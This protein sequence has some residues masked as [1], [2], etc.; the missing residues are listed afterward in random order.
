V[1]EL[2][3]PL[4]RGA[5]VQLIQDMG[6]VVP[7]IITFQ[8]N[9]EKVTRGFKPWNPFDVDATKRTAT[10]TD[11]APF[12][13]EETYQFTL[14]LDATDDIEIV[15]P[16]A[17][18]TGVASRIAAIQKLVMPSSGLIGDLVGAAKALGNK[19]NPAMAEV[20]KLPICLLVMGTGLILPVRV[21][22]ISVEVNEY[23]SFLY[24]LM[25]KVTLDL[26]VLTP[27]AFKCKETVA[28]S[29]AKSAYEFTRLQEDALAILNIANVFVDARSM[30]PF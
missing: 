27:E 18:G 11:A 12:D 1:V 30:L 25:A 2:R 6:F 14:E 22:T 20:K 7:N 17:I 8:Y 29:F 19:G 13:P 4:L 15:N 3:A 26:R 23:N 5:I 16:V 21:T 9:P 24:P 28:T 10:A